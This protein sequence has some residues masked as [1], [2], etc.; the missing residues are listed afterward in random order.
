M[1]LYKEERILG[2]VKCH[3][4]KA[5][6]QVHPR[7]QVGEKGRGQHRVSWKKTELGVR[8]YL[9]LRVIY[10]LLRVKYLLFK[11]RYL[12]QFAVNKKEIRSC[13]FQSQPV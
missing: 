13:S 5:N 7:S 3:K 11:I 8:I 1:D 12:L 6:Q 9:L 2:K 4:P 10:L